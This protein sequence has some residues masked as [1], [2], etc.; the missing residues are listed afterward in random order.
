[1]VDVSESNTP[2]IWKP[3]FEW[4]VVRC[5]SKIDWHQKL[6]VFKRDW[7]MCSKY[8]NH[9]RFNSEHDLRGGGR[10]GE[11]G[12]HDNLMSTRIFDNK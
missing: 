6:H 3:R 12:V 9:F 5:G 11:G 7:I 2:L 4:Y 1:M 10:L 8:A